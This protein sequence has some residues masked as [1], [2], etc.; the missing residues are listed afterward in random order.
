MSGRGSAP[1]LVGAAVALLAVV[2]TAVEAGAATRYDPRLRFQTISTRRFDI[3]F[4]QRE[5]AMARRLAGFVEAAASEVDA[6]IGAAVGRVQIVLVDQHDVS[7]GWAT[8]LPYN[9]IEIGAAAPPVESGIG[10]TADWLRLVFVHEYTHIAHLSRAGGWIRGLRRGFGRVPPL[11]PNLYQPIWGIEGI[12]TWQE[13]RGTHQGRVLAGD[14]RVLLDRAAAAGRFEPIDRVSGGN[15]DWPGGNG[16]YLYGAYFHEFLADK[17]G[18]DSIRRLTDETG[19]RL[20][21]L[22]SRAYKKVFGRSLGQLWKDFKESTSG[23]VKTSPTT[24]AMRLTR[25]GFRVATPRLRADGHL[26]YSSVTPHDF[27]A[28]MELSPGDPTPR[29]VARRYLGGSIGLAAG[30]L[31]V[32]ELDLVRSVA[33]Q[34]DIYV[35]DPVSGERR[36]VTDEARAADPD[37]APDGAS[38]VC[39][40]QMADRRA[41]ATFTLPA[42][43][44]PAAPRILI[45]EP[46]VDFALPRWSPDGRSIVVERRQRGGSAAI[47]LVDAA[48]QRVQTLA[49]LPGGRSGAPVWMPDGSAVLFS[50]AADDEPF[51]IHRVVLA[52]GA[53]ARLEGTGASAQSPEVGPDGRRL[54]FVGY[55]A[56]GYDLFAQDLATAQWTPVSPSSS[57][58]SPSVQPDLA[59]SSAA[60]RAYS[61]WSTLIPT[62]WTP[63]VE[64]DGDELVVGAATGSAD[65]LGRHAYGIEAGWSARTRPDWQVAYAYDRWR[66]TLFAAFSDDTDPWRDGEVRTREADIGALLPFQRVRASH[67]L[68][69]SVHVADDE[70]D[71]GTC[72]KPVDGSVNRR[73]FRTGYVFNSAHEFGYSISAEDGVR[74]AVTSEVSRAAA[75]TN[76]P[77]PSEGSGLSLTADL[78]HYRRLGPRHAVLALR[79][80]AA[81]SWGDDAAGQIFRA[82]GNGPQSGGFGFGVDAIGLLRGFGEDAI[83]GTRAAV[84]NLDYRLPLAR[85]GRGLGSVPLFVRNFHGA[86]FADIGQAWTDTAR[87]RAVS[88]SVGA[89]L[90]ADAVVGFGL[91]LTFTAGAA[92]RRDGPSGDR[93]VVVFG[94]IGR[95]F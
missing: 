68:L 24:R 91:P 80:A 88:A 38:V 15:V 61:P 75:D 1:R 13:S 31:V 79:A 27:P 40:I 73:S 50:A 11:F 21:Y 20:P 64:S 12:A 16:P 32:D 72:E 92:L 59:P 28:L 70:F 23:A 4:H 22:G 41:L 90:S 87:W 93:D 17:Y 71:C 45:S 44:Q 18:A 19:R 53:V 55:T 60:L 14:F 25:Q 67:T 83:T 5:E 63:T 35:V 81:G 58:P 94:R 49:D 10:N 30:H 7:N 86:L 52:T 39:T 46:A 42:A 6:A 57:T 82:S 26:F 76:P 3:H 48:T 84:L 51:R 54:V 65:A 69:A 89:E 62:F 37:V 66:P 2:S 95:A 34:S 36:R 47:A 9:T 29:V 8:P 77:A 33:L 74:A 85:I 78:R 43:G 56:D